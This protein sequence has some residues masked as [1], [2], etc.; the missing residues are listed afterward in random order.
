M[1]ETGES[2]GQAIRSFA[3]YLGYEWKRWKY[4]SNPRNFWERRGSKANF[5][6]YPVDIMA[7]QTDF[8]QQKFTRLQ[9]SSALE[10]GCGYGRILKLN[11]QC[12]PQ[13][14]LIVGMD[15][16]R[17]QLEKAKLFVGNRCRLI[18][19][20]AAALPFEDNAFELVYTIGVLMHIPPR[21]V[22]RALL[23]TIRVSKRY[24]VFAEGIYRHFNMFGLDFRKEFEALGLKTKECVDV[25][26]RVLRPKPIQFV[27]M[28][29]ERPISK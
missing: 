15:F 20:S 14:A 18:Q 16:A 25:S 21:N 4:V 19:A 8:F 3:R 6:T 10:I 5:E 1:G 13:S 28:E 7:E 2:V 24:V 9:V 12:Q 26:F 27:I 17:P 22:Q 23:E 29:K 11:S